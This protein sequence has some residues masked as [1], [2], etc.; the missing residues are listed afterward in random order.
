MD[1]RSPQTKEECFALL[2]AMLSEEDKNELKNC[3]DTIN[4]HFTLGMW[5][6]K[7]FED[8]DRSPY[9]SHFIHP[10]EVSS[11]IID[12]YVKYLIDKD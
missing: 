3:E 1:N 12:K 11:T 5:F 8:E 10:D 2:D 6:M 9:G 4:Y 7:M